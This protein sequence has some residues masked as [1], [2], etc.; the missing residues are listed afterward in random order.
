MRIY[1]TARTADNDLMKVIRRVFTAWLAAVGNT[2]GSKP[3]LYIAWTKRKISNR[4]Q[5]YKRVKAHLDHVNFAG[6]VG[7]EIPMGNRKN[8]HTTNK[9]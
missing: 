2:T 4:K 9:P 5:K 6:T 3:L 1:A 8:F 7:R